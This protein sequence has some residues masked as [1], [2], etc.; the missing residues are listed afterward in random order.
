M[1]R[2]ID[3]VAT[4][5]NLTAGITNSDWTFIDFTVPVIDNF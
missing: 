3:E 4:R 2:N 1:M 5:E